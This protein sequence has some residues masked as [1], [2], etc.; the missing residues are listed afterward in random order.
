MV[1]Y[2]FVDWYYLT[3]DLA[4]N[5][6]DEVQGVVDGPGSGSGSAKVGKRGALHLSVSMLDLLGKLAQSVATAHGTLTG[7][8]KGVV[9]DED[10][11]REDEAVRWSELVGGGQGSRNRSSEA[12]KLFV[13][14]EQTGC[15]LERTVARRWLDEGAILLLTVAEEDDKVDIVVLE[16]NLLDGDWIRL[17]SRRE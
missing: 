7:E 16:E 14:G 1:E 17:L 13:T 10:K 15:L 5:G 9:G 4:N 8:L 6:G 3:D 12:R 11:F 2:V